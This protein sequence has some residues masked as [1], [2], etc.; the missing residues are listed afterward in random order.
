MESYKN[1]YDYKE[2][3]IKKFKMYNPTIHTN[4]EKEYNWLNPDEACVIEIKNTNGENLFIALEDEITISHGTWHDHYY[5]EDR[6]D[7]ESAM[8]KVS[9]IINNLDCTLTIFSNGKCFGSGSELSKNKY[10][11][12]EAIEFIKNLFNGKAY[13]EFTKTFKK[14]GAN[15]KINYWDKTKNY[16]IFLDK[17]EF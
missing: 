10:T 3:I 4:K 8:T 2:E 5:Y 13:E 12:K 9:N 6:Y 16:E 11:K 1:T 17:E 14:Y 15:I 7:Y